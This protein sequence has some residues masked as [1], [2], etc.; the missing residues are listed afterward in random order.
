V[1]ETEHSLVEAARAH[2]AKLEW[3]DAYDAFLRAEQDAP[4]SV[5]DTER[6]AV[7]A[8]MTGLNDEFVRINERAFAA[9]S[10]RGALAEAAYCA[11]WIGFVLFFDGNMGQGQAW[12]GRA[13]RLIEQN[14]GSCV[15]EA[16]LFIPQVQRATGRGD[17]DEALALARRMGEIGDEL[18][19]AEA[20]AGARQ[21]EGAVRLTLGEVETGLACLDEA[22]LLV[23]S[24]DVPAITS[25]MIYCDVV[26]TCQKVLELGRSREWTDALA[27]WSDAQPSM[28]AFAGKCLVLR[29]EVLHMNGDWSD[30]LDAARFACERYRGIRAGAGRAHY[31]LGD[32]LRAVGRHDEAEAQFRRASALGFDPQP[33]LAQLRLSQGK[34][35]AARGAMRRALASEL[36]RLVRIRL[37]YAA[38]EIFVATADLD[39]A[40][41]AST[42][43]DEIARSIGTAALRGMALVSRARVHAARGAHDEALPLIRQAGEAWTSCSAPHELARARVLMG[44]SCRA[45]G[46]EDGAEMELAAALETF[47][48]LGAAPDLVRVRH[49]RD[50]VQEKEGARDASAARSLGNY[51]LVHKIGGGGMGEIWAA[52]HRLLARPAAVKLIRSDR[53]GGDADRAREARARFER[54]ARATAALTSP[55]TV[56]LY[57]YGVADDGAFYYVMELLDGVDLE[58][59]VTEHGP[60]PPARVVHVLREACE[61][62][63]DAHEAGLVHRDIKPANIVLCRRGPRRDFV[64]V[65]DFGLVGLRDEEQADKLTREGTVGGTPA[66]LSPEAALGEEIDGRADLYALGCVAFWLLTGALVFGEKTP[67]AMVIAHA[68]EPPPKLAAQATVPAELESLIMSCLAKDPDQRPRSAAELGAALAA[69]EMGH[70]WTQTRAREWWRARHIVTAASALRADPAATATES[71]MAVPSASTHPTE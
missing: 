17:L 56:E 64:S 10:D 24:G 50:G 21:M 23:L 46:D 43:L 26:A 39:E 30:A 59:L 41:A 8:Y 34:T 36:N 3:S 28:V 40:E 11:T 13:R 68:K 51:D 54:E 14:D 42:E 18:D 62:L 66:Y 7:S 53:V 38:C 61:A 12:H 71:A 22:M 19:S 57:D 20:R 47:H 27:K 55:H 67:T 60:M 44:L 15:A 48:R 63:A 45:L 37:L 33:G 1:G 70:P 69:I 6:L 35:Q 5:G 2:V 65:V 4:L 16:L 52:R 32:L 31:Q 29:A 9:Y 25:G 49:L 58:M